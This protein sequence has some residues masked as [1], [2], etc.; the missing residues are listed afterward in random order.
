MSAI[1]LVGFLRTKTSFRLIS[2]RIGSIHGVDVGSVMG[3]RLIYE[4]EQVVSARHKSA[5]AGNGLPGPESASAAVSLCLLLGRTD[6][7]IDPCGCYG[8]GYKR[9]MVCYR[10]RANRREAPREDLQLSR[11]VRL[12]RADLG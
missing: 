5:D 4:W 6:S 2:A 8:R 12:I 9:S 3:N 1:L 7:G 11:S 10:Q